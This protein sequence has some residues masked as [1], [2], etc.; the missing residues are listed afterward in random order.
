MGGEPDESDAYGWWML[1][2]DS[3]ENGLSEM[4]RGMK[5]QRR[6]IRILAEKEKAAGK[7]DDG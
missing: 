7:M 1:G 5:H 4:V 6:A 2:V 3:I